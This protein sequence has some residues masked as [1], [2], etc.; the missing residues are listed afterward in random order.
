MRTN[1][2]QTYFLSDRRK[3]INQNP[4]QEIN[5]IRICT[6]DMRFKITTISSQFSSFS[7]VHSSIGQGEILMLIVFIVK[8]TTLAKKCGAEAKKLDNAPNALINPPRSLH[9]PKDFVRSRELQILQPLLNYYYF[10]FFW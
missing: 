4:N 6:H 7:Y 1:D 5:V 2:R 10:T 9:R 3:N 8:F